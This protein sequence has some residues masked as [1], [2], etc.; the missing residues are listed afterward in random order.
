VTTPITDS[1]TV[2]IDVSKATFDLAGVPGLA[3]QTFT[4]AP[5]GH[6]EIVA[7]LRQ[8]PPQLIVL[9]ATGNLEAPLVAALVAAQL[10]V[11]VVNPRQV[12]DFA[13]ALGRLAK[14]DRIDADVLVRFGQAVRPPLR[15]VPDE[16]MRQLREL[17][18]RRSQLVQMR[19]AESNR[20]NSVQGKRVCKSIKHLLEVLDKELKK[21]DQDV[22]QLIRDCPAWKEK[23]D[24]LTTVPGIGEQTARMLVADVPE[25][26]TCSRHQICALVGVAPFNN[27]SGKFRGQRTIRGGRSEVRKMLYMATLAATR[28]NAVIQ[29]YYVRL[30]AVG[31]R[32][33][34]ALI[35]CMRKLL[36]I[37]N[38][39]IRKHQTW[40][41]LIPQNT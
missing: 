15:P 11:V 34:V 27:D 31:K 30:L 41:I 29:S 1:Y 18:A 40:Q 23:E 16:Q 3:A 28:F 25:L 36:T 17:L 20:L 12:R 19:V 37:L 26:G 24:L 10:P 21:I 7:L 14:T 2:G 33:K 8:A 38:A 35:A 9:E 5:E 22:D 13:K 39:M 4:N 6:A 32:K